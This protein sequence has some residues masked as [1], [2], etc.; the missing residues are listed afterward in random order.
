MIVLLHNMPSRMPSC[1]HFLLNLPHAFSHAWNPAQT[2][3]MS[4]VEMADT[5][6]GWKRKAFLPQAL[7]SPQACLP[8][9]APMCKVSYCKWICAISP[10]LLPLLQESGWCSASLLH[11]PKAQAPEALRQMHRVL[12][13]GGTLHLGL[14]EGEGEKWEV[15]RFDVERF[16]VRYTLEEAETLL[17][18]TGF[19][20]D[21]RHQDTTGPRHWLNF[22]AKAI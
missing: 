10:F 20:L 12:V 5:W 14:Q 17:T 6:H 7:I 13:P 11:I 9:R 18:Q 8:R 1:H 15:T 3:S 16:F 4:G 19:S 2:Y 21:E 22:L